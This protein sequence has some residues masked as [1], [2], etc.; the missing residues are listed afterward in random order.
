MKF[1]NYINVKK[2]NFKSLNIKNKEQFFIP[3]QNTKKDMQNFF[4]HLYFSSFL[5]SKIF[6]PKI[7]LKYI[8]RKKLLKKEL[9]IQNRVKKSFNLGFSGFKKPKVLNLGKYGPEK[10]LNIYRDLI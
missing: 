1:F 3:L 9:K 4:N 6:R 8:L 5:V 7:Q 10:I 2:I